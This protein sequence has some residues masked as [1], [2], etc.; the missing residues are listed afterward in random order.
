MLSAADFTDTEFTDDNNVKEIMG[1]IHKERETLPR[2]TPYPKGLK[3][4]LV[5]HIK[6]SFEHIESYR[7]RENKKASELARFTEVCGVFS[8]P[9]WY[10][11]VTEDIAWEEWGRA[12]ALKRMEEG[13]TDFSNTK[14]LERLLKDI[15][16]K[17]GN[18]YI[19]FPEAFKDSLADYE[20]TLSNKSESQNLSKTLQIPQLDSWIKEQLARMKITRK[21]IKNESMEQ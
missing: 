13:T 14:N 16:A 2:L 5:L 9:T 15:R 18:S 6:K 17:Q 11:T 20:L 12:Y 7:E 1:K 4:A 8:F 21:R 10:K 19:R 3:K